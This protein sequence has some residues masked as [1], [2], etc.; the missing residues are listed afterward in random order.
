MSTYKHPY[1]EP[2]HGR[3]SRHI[4]PSCKQNQ[5]FTFYLDG[6]TGERIHPSVG[7]CN[8]EINCRY[9]YTPKQFFEDHP[10]RITSNKKV[11]NHQNNI[12]NNVSS[13]QKFTQQITVSKQTN[14]FEILKEKIDYVPRKYVINSASYNSN[15]VRFLCEYF[16]SEKIEEAVKHY[17]LGATRRQHVIFWQID[18]NGNIRTGKIMQYNPMT[19]RRVKDGKGNINWVHSILK[20]RIPL[21]AKYNLCQ[22]YFGEHMLRLFPEKP[23]AVVESEKTAV[24]GSMIYS[25]FIWLA[26]GSLNGLTV[27]KSKVLKDRYVMLYPDAGCFEKWT[28]RMKN[29]SRDVNCNINISDFIE[30]HVNDEQ[31]EYGY[32]VADYIIDKL[33]LEEIPSAIDTMETKP[34]STQLNEMIEKNQS[35]ANLID[36]FG[37]EEK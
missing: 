19:G 37:L 11:C 26:T 22:C 28:G 21:F 25:D 12:D 18:I 24:M 29:I 17:A 6:N 10:E 2:Y 7:K 36:T 30:K 32:D 35:L 1:L 20:K 8:R 15:F 31:L 34:N 13:N 5:T 23:V 3:E 9:H 4:C 27:P 14:V 16:P 33:I